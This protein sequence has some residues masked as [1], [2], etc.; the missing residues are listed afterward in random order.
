MAVNTLPRMPRA[1]QPVCPDKASAA[2]YATPSTASFP[3]SAGLLLGLGVGGVF[4]GI[5]FHQILQWHHMLSSAG[6]PPDSLGNLQLNTLADGL[7]HAATY[8]FVLWGLARLWRA[9]RQ[10]HFRWSSGLLLASMLMG[11]GLFN[12]VEGLIN[13]YLL[14]I[15]HVNEI[16]PPAQWIYWDIGF[17]LWGLAMLVGGWLLLR[18]AR[19]AQSTQSIGAAQGMLASTS[20]PASGPGPGPAPAPA[21]PGVNLASE[22][23]AGEEDPGASL[24]MGANAPGSGAGS[25]SDAG[26]NKPQ[27]SGS[28]AGNAPG[29]KPVSEPPAPLNPGDEAAPE[30]PGTGEGICRECGG[31]GRLG[32]AICPACDGPGKVIAGVGGA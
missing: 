2:P 7:F 6:Y 3:L 16:V 8:V 19:A 13:H 18:R 20:A 10:P 26:F 29:A 12:L 32:G 14:G 31:S 25:G 11:F 22:S 28:G 27:D 23:V 1:A 9:A 30:T 15:H 5:V 4:D 17:L 24:D 21:R